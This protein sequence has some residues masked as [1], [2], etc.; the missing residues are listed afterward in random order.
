MGSNPILDLFKLYTIVYM[1]HGRLT[2]RW[3]FI[4]YTMKNIYSFRTIK[5]QH[6]V[7]YKGVEYSRCEE[8]EYSDGDIV[9]IYEIKWLLRENGHYVEYFNGVPY[10]GNDNVGWELKV[11]GKF[12]HG[13]YVQDIPQL[14]LAYIAMRLL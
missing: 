11:D 9:T 12:V 7:E 6:V 8:I 13:K 10:S 14:E 1:P 4:L 5:N 2:S 3:I